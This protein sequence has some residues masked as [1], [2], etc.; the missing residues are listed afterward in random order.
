MNYKVVYFSRTGVSEKVAKKI[1]EKLDCEVFEITDD[2]NWKGPIGF[3]KGG[4]YATQ[5]KPVN[6]TVHGNLDNA[7]ELV[8]VSPVWANRVAP[9]ITVFLEKRDLKTIHLVTTSKGSIV[10]NQ[11]DYKTAHAIIEKDN[12]ETAV[13]ANLISLLK[14]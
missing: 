3:V 13:I 2:M 8:V 11:S 6:I 1:A 5:N 9:A 4:M 14:A 12:N 7:D 10:N